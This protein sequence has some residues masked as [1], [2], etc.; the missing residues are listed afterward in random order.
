MTGPEHYREAERLLKVV[1]EHHGVV[2]GMDRVLAAAQ[3]HAT[4]AH[5]AATALAEG[6]AGGM[7]IRDVEDW[8][9]AASSA[10]VA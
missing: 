9:E 2:Q 10:G 3:V 6:G 7:H 8:H 1:S 5:A 4:L